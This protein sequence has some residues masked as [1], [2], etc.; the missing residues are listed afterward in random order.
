MQLAKEQN[1]LFFCT[2]TC[3]GWLP[4]IKLTNTYDAVYKWFDYLHQRN[5]YITAFVIMPNH[6]H[7]ILYF[8][9]SNFELAKIIGNA[10]RFLAY[11]I[12]KKLQEQNKTALLNKLAFATT[13]REAGKG[14]KHKVFEASFNV[15]EIYSSSFL[16]QKVDYIHHNPVCGKWNLLGDFTD[17]EHSSASFYEKGIVKHFKPFDFR[18]I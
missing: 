5:W 8:P 16:H 14:Q 11:E 18:K 10:K 3:H 12:I 6:I 15:N 17:Y 7:T 2:F 1:Q 9:Q 4:L 13:N